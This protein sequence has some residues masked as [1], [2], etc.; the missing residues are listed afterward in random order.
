MPRVTKAII[1]AAGLGTRQ[2]PAT[3]ATRKEFF[4]LADRDG[5]SKPVIQIVV[6]EA[7]AGG[8]EEV[9]IVCQPGAE[10][11][12]RRYFRPMPEDLRARFSGKDWALEQSEQLR[13]L[14]ECIRYVVQERQEGLGHAV[15]CAR[16]WAGGEPVL[17]L[18][19]DHVYVSTTE[20][21]CAAQLT[22]AYEALGAHEGGSLTA[23]VP[24]GPESLPRFGVARGRPAD[25]DGRQIVA[26]GF[27]EKPDEATARTRCRIEGLPAD[28]YLAHF[29]MHVFSPGIFE[30][31][32]EMVRSDR[33]D[34]GEFQLTTA[35]DIL[36]AREPYAGLVM[37]GV[38]YD[39][40]TPSGLLE[41]QLALAVSG[42]LRDDVQRIWR[43]T[44]E[45]HLR[46]G[47]P[48]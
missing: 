44:L 48:Q 5:F 23:L 40:G 8:A 6:E 47:S 15:W 28:T 22:S 24:V 17:A 41:A 42:R 11:E 3:Q 46:Q 10:E 4:P 26:E 14:G 20:V 35:Q 16:E 25:R 9:C 32:D 21:R 36:C 12:F 45:N 33:R 43:R 1:P 13:R 34:R 31:L 38:H 19:G 7:L 37:D 27:I 2:Y 39:I 29:G 30:V 18:L